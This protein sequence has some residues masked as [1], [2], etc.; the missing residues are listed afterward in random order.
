MVSTVGCGS[1]DINVFDSLYSSV[2]KETVKIMNGWMSTTIR[3]KRLWPLFDG[4]SY[5]IG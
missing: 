3:D 4:D 1:K 5:C 2:G